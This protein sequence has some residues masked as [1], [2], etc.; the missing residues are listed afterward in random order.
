MSTYNRL[1]GESLMQIDLGAHGIAG[2][3]QNT[4]APSAIPS[5]LRVSLPPVQA[6]R[7]TNTEV[8]GMSFGFKAVQ[9][10]P[11]G[12]NGSPLG[13]IFPFSQLICGVMHVSA[14]RG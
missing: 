3:M 12:H 9:V 13:D 6:R 4:C 8:L 11:Y 10:V 14:L 2:L 7:L 1:F 5:I